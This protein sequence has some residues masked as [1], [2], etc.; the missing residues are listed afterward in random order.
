[1]KQKGEPVFPSPVLRGLT[2]KSLMG[3]ALFAELIKSYSS[4][5]PSE[6]IISE[7]K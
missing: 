1:M 4:E 3:R 5:G 2:K 6:L 7:Y